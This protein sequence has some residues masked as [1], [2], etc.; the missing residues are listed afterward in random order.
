MEYGAPERIRTSDPQIRRLG[1]GAENPQDCCKP[2]LDP[3]YMDQWVSTRVANLKGTFE[4]VGST[5]FRVCVPAYHPLQ[6]SWTEQMAT[7]RTGRPRGRPTK[8]LLQDPDRFW[9]AYAYA[10]ES[11]GLSERAAFD[12]IAVIVFGEVD[13]F[14][15]V[16]PR[17]RRGGLIR[18]AGVLVRSSKV[19]GSS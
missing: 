18:P 15:E 7:P 11:V 17:K 1:Q 19:L 6:E 14:E 4:Q 13:S 9:I 12:R 3:A 16:R 2:S 5:Q 10:M 8:P